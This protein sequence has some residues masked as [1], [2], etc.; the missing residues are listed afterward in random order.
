MELVYIGDVVNTH[1]LKG[2]VR[3][4]SDFKYKEQVFNKG[5]VLYVGYDKVPLTIN[6]YRKHKMFDMLTFKDISTIDDVIRYKGDKV[7]I[8][9]ADFKFPGLI[10]VDIIGLDVY[11]EKKYIGKVKSILKNMVH[12]ILVVED[13]E[14]KNMIPFVDEFVVN[15]DLE[16]K[17][18]V[19]KTIEGLIN[20]NWYFNSFS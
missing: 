5:N 16:D 2:E 17:K 11:S 20:E 7:Y 3:L 6:S 15:V 19:I 8:N 12:D 1:G 13:G 4:L 14:N 18:I 9:R 10:D